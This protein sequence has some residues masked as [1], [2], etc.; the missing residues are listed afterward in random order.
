MKI[1]YLITFT[2]MVSILSA[3]SVFANEEVNPE[4]ISTPSQKVQLLD[5]NGIMDGEEAQCFD[6]YRFGSLAIDATPNQLEYQPG[7]VVILTGSITNNNPY[8]LVDV[9]V[10]ARVIK[11]IPGSNDRARTVTIEEVEVIKDKTLKANEKFE[12]TTSFVLSTQAPAGQYE[13][14]FFGYNKDRFNLSGLSFT[15]DIYGSKISFKVGGSNKEGIY[16]DQTKTTVG[17]KDH[18]N[19][20]FVTQHDGKSPVEIKIPLVNDNPN[21]TPIRVKYELY[22]WDSLRE[23]QKIREL[24]EEF[25]LKPGERK[26]LSYTVDALTEPVYYVKLTASTE[27]SPAQW[28]KSI[29][30]IRFVIQ[31]KDKLRINYSGLT[32]FPKPSGSESSVVTC[33]HNTN[34]KELENG[35]VQTIVSDVY[36]REVA[37]S[38]YSGK[39]PSAISAIKT[40]LPTNNQYNQLIVT[41]KIQDKDGNLIDTV[42]TKYDC[43]KIDPSQCVKESVITSIGRGAIWVVILGISIGLA[44]YALWMQRGVFQSLKLRMKK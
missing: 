41:T 28:Q 18:I 2:L 23:E 36:G 17:G 16:W 24:D 7:E 10:S 20:A 14:M 22:W 33:F 8:P 9:T 29:S 35:K 11:N 43:Q 15:D 40:D 19:H 13:V 1:R 34:N 44:G 32:V 4:V 31:D 39:I 26:E 42:T 6:T 21:E 5:Q 12:Y 38:S 3:V 25:I 30:N 27:S 37:R